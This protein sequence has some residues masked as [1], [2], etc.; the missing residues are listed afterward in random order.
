MRV[1]STKPDKS[2]EK[3]QVCTEC[4][5]KFAYV[6]KD[7]KSWVGRDMGGSCGGTYVECPTCTHHVTLTSW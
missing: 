5:T 6:P 4:G 7:T 1:I 3:T 2:V